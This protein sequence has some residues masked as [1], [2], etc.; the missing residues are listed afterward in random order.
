MSDDLTQLEQLLA[1]FESNHEAIGPLE[2]E[3]LTE[4]ILV[5]LLR[6]EAYQ[7]TPCGAVPA[8]GFDFIAHRPATTEQAQAVIGIE[9]KHYRSRQALSLSSVR[10]LLGAALVSGFDRVMLVGSTGFTRAAREAVARDLPVTAELVDFETLREWIR[11]SRNRRESPPPN[12]TI[13][14][15]AGC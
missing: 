6:I 13:E 3:R 12:A 4:Q 15:L 5:P 1:H 14:D 11:S 7:V 2:A 8:R 10:E 9:L